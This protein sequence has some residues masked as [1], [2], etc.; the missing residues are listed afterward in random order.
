MK[1]TKEGRSEIET[2]FVEKVTYEKL[3]KDNRTGVT[4]LRDDSRKIEMSEDG[5]GD[6]HINDTLKQI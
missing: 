5:C 3:W 1:D 2:I 4:L 6:L